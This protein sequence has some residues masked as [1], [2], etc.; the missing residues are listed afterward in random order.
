M[1][2]AHGA[3]C[4]L[5]CDRILWKSTVEPDPDSDDDKSDAPH[6]KA[7]TRVGQFFAKFKMRHRKRSYNSPT[8]SEVSSYGHTPP[9][10]SRDEVRV[11]S[12]P[13]PS[14]PM[15]ALAGGK[16]PRQFSR[17]ATLENTTPGFDSS[18]S[19]DN[20]NAANVRRTPG[21]G[22][23]HSFSVNQAQPGRKSHSKHQRFSHTETTQMKPGPL[24]ETPQPTESAPI[25][26]TPKDGQAPRNG[27]H[28][29]RFLPFLRGG[30]GQTTV[31]ID[32][33]LNL[34]ESTE[35][36]ANP[37]TSKPRKGDVVCLGYDS[38]DDKAMRR[39]E[40]RSDHRPVIGSYAIYL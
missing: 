39:L 23:P 30:S 11:P 32:P 1:A 10:S 2:A 36:T 16:G 14:P 5:R 34:G 9:V 40:G 3:V 27:P 35:V 29:W 25:T 24:S 21:A 33:S 31:S 20:L 17:F 8:S 22:L 7:R 26:T 38:L 28:R 18:G 6:P 15:S 12:H 13:L 37:T 4:A 19:A